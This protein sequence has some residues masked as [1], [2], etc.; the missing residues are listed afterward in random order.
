MSKKPLPRSTLSSTKSVSP[1]L[2]AR[3]P[4]VYNQSVDDFFDFLEPMLAHDIS[5]KVPSSDMS[6]SEMIKRKRLFR[7]YDDPSRL[8]ISILERRLPRAYSQTNRIQWNKNDVGR[9]RGQIQ[10][11]LTRLELPNQLPEVTFTTAV[12][13]GN[14]D[15]GD[16]NRKIALIPDQ[17]SE[18]SEFFLEE[19][20]ICM[21]GL[22]GSMRRFKHPYSSFI[23]HLTVCRVHK[24]SGPLGMRAGVHAVQKLLPVTFQIEQ[25]QFVSIS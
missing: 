15:V 2:G 17:E 1:E 12:R 4:I 10:D 6:E 23:P 25:I 8:G 20:E 19:H 16:R 11:K 13:L 18:I 9:M 7:L 3:H 24:E 21:D 22:A 14:P 5:L